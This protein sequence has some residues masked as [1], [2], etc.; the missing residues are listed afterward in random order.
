[1]TNGLTVSVHRSNFTTIKRS[2]LI[3]NWIK[4]FQVKWLHWEMKKQIF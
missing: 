1:M 3:Q 2:T 4:V